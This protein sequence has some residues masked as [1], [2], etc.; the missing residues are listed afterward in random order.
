MSILLLI[1]SLHIYALINLINY[2]ISSVNTGDSRTIIQGQKTASTW[3]TIIKL[4]SFFNS[5]VVY[6][7]ELLNHNNSYVDNRTM[8]TSLN[9]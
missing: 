3:K 8:K 9:T 7:K 6:K 5:F 4:N 1:L 2:N